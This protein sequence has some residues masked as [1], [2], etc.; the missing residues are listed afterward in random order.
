MPP[1]QAVCYA[2]HCVPRDPELS[3]YITALHPRAAKP[4][5]F[6]NI[7]LGQR[8][9]TDLRPN[10]DAAVPAPV[11]MILKRRRP[12]EI[13]QPVV[14]L[15][16]VPVRGLVTGRG[17]RAIEGF[18][19]QDVQEFRLALPVSAETHRQIAFRVLPGAEY[20]SD[21][22]ATG[23]SDDALYAAIAGDVVDFLEPGAG[24]PHLRLR[25]TRFVILDDMSSSHS[26]LH[27]RFVS[28]R[29]G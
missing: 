25:L 17:F 11:P 18:T 6:P 3:P 10:Q 8:R 19:H 1:P 13:A 29:A 27:R 4:P 21:L 2:A 24:L 16:I 22:G 12:V 28:V 9:S 15:V 26:N 7:A 20:S 5:Y 23:T 14:F